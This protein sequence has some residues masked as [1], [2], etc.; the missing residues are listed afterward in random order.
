MR[1]YEF[2]SEAKF[3]YSLADYLETP[4]DTGFEHYEQTK[5]EHG[6]E[7]HIGPQE[8]KYLNLMLRR[9]KPATI[10]STDNERQL[11]EPYIKNGTVKVAAKDDYNLF[12]T[13]PGEEWR[14]PKLQKLFKQ[15]YALQDQPEYDVQAEKVVNAKIGRL[16]GIPKESVRYFLKTR[17]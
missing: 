6:D 17:Y 8:G 9:M 15:M 3:D 7:P 4:Y 13:L 2:L 1:A 10:I 16:L 11:F 14:G 5:K 12:L